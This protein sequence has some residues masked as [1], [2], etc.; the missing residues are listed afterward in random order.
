[1]KTLHLSGLQK[2]VLQ[3]METRLHKDQLAETH[4]LFEQLDVDRTGLIRRHKLAEVLQQQ[5]FLT[6]SL[7]LTLTLTLSPD[8]SPDPDPD[9]DPDPNLNPT[10]TLALNPNPNPNP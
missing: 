3:V 10:L 2:I 9:P 6:V 1:M 5:T 4:T 8:P 7:S